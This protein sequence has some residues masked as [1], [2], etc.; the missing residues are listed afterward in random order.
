MTMNNKEFTSAKQLESTASES[1]SLFARRRQ[2][3]S[4]EDLIATA[5]A[6]RFQS[7]MRCAKA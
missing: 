5:S 1:R 3:L 2:L 6:P 7:M 4:E